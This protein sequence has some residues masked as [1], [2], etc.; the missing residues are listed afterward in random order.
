MGMWR[1]IRRA[2]NRRFGPKPSRP[3]LARQR[4]RWSLVLEPIG[5]PRTAFEQPRGTV[6]APA[7]PG[8][9]GK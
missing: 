6:V 3:R 9:E 8:R 5:E 2:Y 7:G 4:R 1:S